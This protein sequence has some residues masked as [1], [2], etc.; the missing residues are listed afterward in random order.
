MS[1]GIF[2]KYAERRTEIRGDSSPVND[3]ETD[4]HTAGDCFGC[5][6]G[7]ARDRAAMLEL[8][9]ADGHIMAIGYAWLESLEFEPSEGITL[10]LSG[11]KVRIKGRNL[12]RPSDSHPRLFAN[13]IAHRVLW[14]QET[15]RNAQITAGENGVE[16]D[17]IE[18]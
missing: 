9:K 13:I 15:S 14:V 16:I 10:H 18:W 6:R 5:L 2:T 8:R 7:S 11:K 4:V 12:N 3:T 1:E 17:E